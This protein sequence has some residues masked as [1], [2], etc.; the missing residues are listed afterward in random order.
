MVSPQEERTIIMEGLVGNAFNVQTVVFLFGSWLARAGAL[1]AP[2]SPGLCLAIGERE[3]NWNLAANF[4]A[5]GHVDPILERSLIIEFL[6]VADRGGTDIRL[7]TNAPYRARAWPRSSL[8]TSLWTWR[9]AKSFP[10]AR[11]A[12]ISA[13]E[14]EAAVAGARWRC[15]SVERH[16]CRYLHILDAQAVAAVSTKCRTSARRLQSGIRRLN[17]LLLAT[18]G[19]PLYGYCDTGDMPADAPSRRAKGGGQQSQASGSQGECEA[20][21]GT[22][23]DAA[24]CRSLSADAPE[25]PDGGEQRFGLLDC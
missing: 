14:L 22:Q 24:R 16:R 10:W 7:D 9:I 12:H 23:Y 13:L 5:A 21:A 25:V 18:A 4:R 19:Y 17:A 15:R 6:R 1:S 8:R 20:G 11:P 2:V 3:P